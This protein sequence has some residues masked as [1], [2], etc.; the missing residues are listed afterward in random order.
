MSFTD[1]RTADWYD[2][3]YVAKDYAG[4]AAIVSGLLKHKHTSL[5]EYGC[6]TGRYLDEFKRQGWG[7][8]GVEPSEPM[9]MKARERGH[10]VE[11]GLI[12][13]ERDFA[14][15]N[16]VALFNVMGYACADH[17]LSRIL[18][19][20]RDNLTIDGVFVFDF[21]NV[22]AAAS[23]LRL[24]EVST[25]RRDRYILTRTM[26]KKFDG[27]TGCLRYDIHYEESV[28]KDSWREQHL[29][30]CFTVPEVREAVLAAGM[31]P[32]FHS[33]RGGNAEGDDFYILCRAAK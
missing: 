16:A 3:L 15:P 30:R 26:Y 6:G 29:V 13:A 9:L 20:V 11:C 22:V 27:L 17:S 18:Q 12:G 8:R 23:R 25:A 2:A 31:K 21:I 5:L 4:E 10:K 1:Q 14:C 33:W 28:F 7:V 19:G 32:T 24:A